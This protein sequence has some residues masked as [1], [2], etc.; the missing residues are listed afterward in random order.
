MTKLSGF[1]EAVGCKV[2]GEAFTNMKKKINK[3]DDF[4]VFYKDFMNSLKTDDTEKVLAYTLSV[5]FVCY[6]S[7]KLDD[8]LAKFDWLNF[9]EKKAV[10]ELILH[11][12][13]NRTYKN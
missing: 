10:E 6:K 5:L 11:F 7:E 4:N 8:N 3:Y 1:K 9:R 13:K 12:N 2:C